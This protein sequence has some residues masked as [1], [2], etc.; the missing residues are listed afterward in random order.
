MN[1]PDANQFTISIADISTALGVS[2]TTLWRLFR[3]Q[4]MT[5]ARI[6]RCKFYMASD[7]VT[8]LRQRP[9]HNPATETTLLDIDKQR[10]QNRQNEAQ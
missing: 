1:I 6:E 4:E 10:R 3:G 2:R 7:I 9:N 8:R 5:H